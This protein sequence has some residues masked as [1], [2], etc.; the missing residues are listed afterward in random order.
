[1]SWS[2]GGADILARGWGLGGAR[3]NCTL[4]C[5]EGEMGRRWN[6]VIKR[7]CMSES[8]SNFIRVYQWHCSLLLDI[9]QGTALHDGGYLDLQGSCN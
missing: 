9:G 1:M 6:I 3:L 4:G 5:D 2:W 7:A 8:S